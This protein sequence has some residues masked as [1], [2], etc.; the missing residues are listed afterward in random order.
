MADSKP[1]MD[2]FAKMKETCAG[3]PHGTRPRYISGCKCIPCRAA[4]SRYQTQRAVAI[5]RG[6]WNGIVDAR[7]ARLPLKLL[8]RQGIG[9]DSVAAACDIR[10]T[11]I[12]LIR[13]GLKRRVRARTLDR[14]LAVD[15][16]ARAGGSLV[17]AQA[18]KLLIDELVD[19]GYSRKQL[20]EWMGYETPA[21]QFPSPMITA[22]RAADFQRLYTR[23]RAGLVSRNAD[24]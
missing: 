17:S 20:A 16:A 13:K 3:K 15:E 8:S 4:N 6:E 2:R 7:P 14:I 1:N 10:A 19:D 18:T 5:K 22:Q 12:D 23:I 24:S 9:R 21:L 11:T